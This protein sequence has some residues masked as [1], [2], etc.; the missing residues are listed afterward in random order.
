[1]IRYIIIAMVSF[2]VACK[3]RPLQDTLIGTWKLRDMADAGDSI[4]GTATFSKTNIFLL[5]TIVNGKV[6]DTKNCTY[7]ISA[8]NKYLTTKIDTSTFRFE[9][10]KL[11]KGELELKDAEKLNVTTRYVRYKD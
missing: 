5:K 6:T 4:I 3:S 11:T 9:I 1:M 10:I 8:D 2:T 7:E